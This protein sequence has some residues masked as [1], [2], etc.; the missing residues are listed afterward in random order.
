M[1]QRKKLFPELQKRHYFNSSERSIHWPLIQKQMAMIN[2]QLKCTPGYLGALLSIYRE[3]P[4]RLEELFSVVGLQ[5]R[6][7]LIIWYFQNKITIFCA[8]KN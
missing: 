5:L 6:P 4:F 2:Y 8:L 7:V 1:L 3:F